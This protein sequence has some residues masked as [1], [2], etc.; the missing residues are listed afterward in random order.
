MKTIRVT[1]RVI[2]RHRTWN[3][4]KH[5]W[6]KTDFVCHK[7]LRPLEPGMNAVKTSSSHYCLSCA[8]S[9]YFDSTI[10]VTDEELENF[11]SAD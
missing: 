3:I 1:S 2:K 4:R 7:C 9:I 5:R 6:D 8:D 10:A 11:F